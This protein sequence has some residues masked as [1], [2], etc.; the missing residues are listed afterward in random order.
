MESRVGIGDLQKGTEPELLRIS[1]DQPRE[2]CDGGTCNS[3]LR[4]QYNTGTHRL[5]IW[6]YAFDLRQLWESCY[7]YLWQFFRLYC[8]KIG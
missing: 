5:Y 4:F 8:L 3:T 1:P 7:F 6:S 2:R